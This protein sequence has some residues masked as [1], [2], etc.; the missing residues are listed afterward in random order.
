MKEANSSYL[1]RILFFLLQDPC[2]FIRLTSRNGWGAANPRGNL[3]PLQGPA[4][5]VI[6]EPTGTSKQSRNAMAVAQRNAM[7]RGEPDID[8]NYVV[9]DDN[10]SY[11]GDTRTT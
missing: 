7:Q 4:K 11:E 8:F 10:V 1:R 3:R 9:G 5:Y 6:V 2:G